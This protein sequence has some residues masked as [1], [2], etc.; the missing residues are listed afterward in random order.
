MPD[1]I[2]SAIAS[3]GYGALFLATLVEGPVA[4]VFGAFMASQALMHISG[5]FLIAV[6]GDLTG[7]VLL[8]GLGMTGRITTL[9]FCR[10]FY[11]RNAQQ[12]RPLVAQFRTHPGRV[13]VTAKL[14]HAAGFIVL[15]SAGAARIPFW[16]FVGFNFLAALPKSAVLVLLGYVAGAAWAQINTW[17]WVFSCLCMA[18]LCIAFTLYL[19]RRGIMALSGK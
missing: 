3:F 17:L 2:L 7:D 18:I 19:R 1:W 6:A 5:V 14:T 8:Y 12:I 10:R 11:L 16:R 9:P 4:T 15:L 13:L